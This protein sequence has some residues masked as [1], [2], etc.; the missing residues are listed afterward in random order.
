MYVCATLQRLNNKWGQSFMSINGLNVEIFFVCCVVLM[1]ALYIFLFY[2][3]SVPLSLFHMNFHF[4]DMSTKPFLC[5]FYFSFSRYL[6]FDFQRQQWYFKIIFFIIT[7][8]NSSYS[9]LATNSIKL[10]SKGRKLPS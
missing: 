4:L 9:Q 2:G 7:T 5:F 1:L 10:T 3:F 6:F 8:T